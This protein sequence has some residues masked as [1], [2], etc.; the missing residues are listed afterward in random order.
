LA[1]TIVYYIK[2]KKC[3]LFLFFILKTT[4]AV[5]LKCIVK[6]TSTVHKS[7]T[8]AKLALSALRI[9]YYTLQKKQN[10]LKPLYIDIHWHVKVHSLSTMSMNICN[11]FEVYPRCFKAKH[12][13]IITVTAAT[14]AAQQQLQQRLLLLLL[15]LLILPAVT[16]WSFCMSIPFQ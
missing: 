11:I 14:A 2:D 5:I 1:E 8:D 9:F 13:I 12:C 6:L 15:L 3:V 10:C 7:K 4:L 16:H